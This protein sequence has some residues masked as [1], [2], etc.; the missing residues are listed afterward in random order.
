MV[1]L[2]V[3]KYEE[4]YKRILE[5][6]AKAIKEGAGACTVLLLVADDPDAICALRILIWLLKQDNI[7]YKTVPIG[8]YADLS[9]VNKETIEKSREIK[10]IVMINCG[11][12][13]DINDYLSLVDDVTVIVIDSHRPYN[14][15]NIFFNEQVIHLDDGDIEEMKDVQEAF[16]ALEFGPDGDSSED[17]DDD[18]GMDAYGDDNKGSTRNRQSNRDTDDVVAGQKRSSSERDDDSEMD[19]DDENRDLENWDDDANA[20]GGGGG[21]RERPSR[22]R[23]TGVSSADD[24]IRIQSERAVRRERKNRYLR[25]LEKYYS[26]ATYYGQSSSI[27]A[28]QL[29][30][31]LGRPPTIDSMWWAIVGVSSQFWLDQISRDGYELIVSS[32]NDTVS[33]IC[34]SS[35]NT[36]S[37]SSTSR[38]L[39]SSKQKSKQKSSI[40]QQNG[41]DSGEGDSS[42]NGGGQEDGQQVSK[43]MSSSKD[44]QQVTGVYQSKEFRFTLLRHWSLHS[45]MIYSPFVVTRLASWTSRGRSRLDLLMAK[46]GLS[47]MEIR[48][49]F[50][51]LDPKLKRQLEDQF[52]LVGRDFDLSGSMYPSFIRDYGWRKAKVS[53]NDVVQ[54]IAALLSMTGTKSDTIS[55]N[56]GG[57]VTP[58]NAPDQQVVLDEEAERQRWLDGFYEAYDALSQ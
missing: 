3:E 37:A 31:Q 19:N 22:K 58:G 29:I 44:V 26:Q 2:D 40:M 35:N 7:A 11:G 9:R 38:I 46:L 50:T 51:H 42:V 25:I 56:G 49:P 10:S 53:A 12:R 34:I 23:R 32:M 39:Y 47:L 41:F 28:Y 30:E 27:C 57:E 36:R 15:Y 54:S 18:T 48:E 6:S 55:N 21:G 1:Y 8:N 17:D 43:K 33:R 24:F 20:N 14:L 5:G 4:A 13:V 16:E 45:A 52:E